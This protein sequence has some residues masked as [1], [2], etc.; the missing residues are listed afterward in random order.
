MR[1]RIGEDP[2]PYSTQIL[3]SN[4]IIDYFQINF[5]EYLVDS[6]IE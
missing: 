3:L 6:H 1:E 4:F 2:Y 5:T